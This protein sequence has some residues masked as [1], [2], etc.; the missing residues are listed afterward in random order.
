[1]IAIFIQSKYDLSK[2]T[3]YIKNSC[4]YNERKK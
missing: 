1:M 2:K 3:L 4:N